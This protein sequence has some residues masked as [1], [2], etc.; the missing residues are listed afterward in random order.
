MLM[1]SN[2][3]CIEFLTG[4][5]TATVTFNSRRHITRI[6]RL[7]GDRKDDFTYFREN[8]DGS[9]CAKIP[10]KWIKINPG[11]KT[12][13]LLTEEQKEELRE[14]MKRARSEKSGGDSRT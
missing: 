8:E 7:Y 9:I 11:S 12:P 4:Q 10:L 3:N 14:R 13:R 2:E 6:K 5:Q 1:D